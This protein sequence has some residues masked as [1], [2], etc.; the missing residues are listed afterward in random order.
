MFKELEESWEDCRAG[1][2]G[3]LIRGEAREAST[4]QEKKPFLCP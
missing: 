1:N 2:K 4:G 3:R